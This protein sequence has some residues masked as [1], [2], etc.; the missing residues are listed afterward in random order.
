MFVKQLH[1]HAYVRGVGGR[2]KWPGKTAS[3]L[4]S[5]PKFDATSNRRG[6]ICSYIAKVT[7]ALSEA[8]DHDT[9]G[10]YGTFFGFVVLAVIRVV[11]YVR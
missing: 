8:I 1:L 5:A 2:H 4:N 11:V 6:K 3:A 10:P 7:G 9:A